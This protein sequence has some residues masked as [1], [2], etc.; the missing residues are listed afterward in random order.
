MTTPR[1]RLLVARAAPFWRRVLSDLVDLALLLG[2][3][4]LLW[5]IGRAH[6]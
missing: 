6:V 5:E 3:A 4:W 2:F 1:R